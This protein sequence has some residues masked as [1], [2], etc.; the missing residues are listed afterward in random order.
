MKLFSFFLATMTLLGALFGCAATT[1]PQFAIRPAKQDITP[2]GPISGPAQKNYLRDNDPS[3]VTFVATGEKFKRVT[4][5]VDPKWKDM[6][7]AENMK[8]EFTL[9]PGQRKSF[10]FPAGKHNVKSVT[11]RVTA[12][13]GNWE[14]GRTF[15]VEVRFDGHPQILYLYD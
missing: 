13:H 2:L 14:A 3:L 7:P 15:D 1:A 8:R 9:A 4:V 10:W 5:A 6:T 11:E 12:L